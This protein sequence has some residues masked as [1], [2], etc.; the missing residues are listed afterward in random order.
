MLSHA[1]DMREEKYAVHKRLDVLMFIRLFWKAW[2]Y[3]VLTSI[4][5]DGT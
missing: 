4:I 5:E 1:A 2:Q 3:E